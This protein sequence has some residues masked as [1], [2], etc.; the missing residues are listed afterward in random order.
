MRLLFW[1]SFTLCLS[2]FSRYVELIRPQAER[3]IA[4][5]DAQNGL[6]IV[7]ALCVRLLAFARSLL[8]S[9]KRF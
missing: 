4:L 7:K 6:V 5:E 9:E 8:P 3:K 2:C 1:F